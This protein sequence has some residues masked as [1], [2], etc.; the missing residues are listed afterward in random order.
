MLNYECFE[1]TWKGKPP[2][3]LVCSLL[4]VQQPKGDFVMTF[5][6]L[7]FEKLWSGFTNWYD[8]LLVDSWECGCRLL[9]WKCFFP[10]RLFARLFKASR[11]CS[12]GFQKKK[13]AF[14]IFPWR[15]RKTNF[16]EMFWMSTRKFIGRLLLGFCK[17]WTTQ[18]FIVQ[19][20]SMT[21]FKNRHGQFNEQLLCWT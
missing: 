1:C 10:S 9:I 4:K 17:I 11:S 6:H 2:N 18:N 12:N 20:P 7:C 8:I 13:T 21:I 15:M 19:I 3:T 14:K 5:A 16:R